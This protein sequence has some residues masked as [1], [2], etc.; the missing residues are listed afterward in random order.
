[1]AA[2]GDGSS[3]PLE[4][5][6]PLGIGSVILRLGGIG[7]VLLCSAGAFA[8]TGGWLSPDRVTP[9]KL[10]AGF[11]A[12][13][14]P[15]PGFRRNH[16]KGVCATGMFETA[17]GEAAKLSKATVFAAPRTPV[18]A[19]I[20]FAGG[21]PAVPD[22]TALVRSLALQLLP[23]GGGEWRTGMINIPVFPFRTARD[24]YDQAQAG[25]PDPATG[26][27]DPAKMQAFV[28]A[29]PDFARAG[30]L[31]GKR[32]V[33]S[34]FADTTYNGLHTFHFIG[35]DGAMTP[36]RWSAVPVDPVAPAAS[37][38]ATAAG[39]S[40]ALFDAFIT[41]MAQG[42]V[43]WRLV[44]TVGGATETTDPSRPWPDGLRTVEAGTVTLA[45]VEAE[46]GGPCTRV[47][48]DPLV[49]PDGIKRSDDDEIISTRSAAYARSFRLR[50]GEASAKPPSAVTSADVQKGGRS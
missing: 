6:P 31:I 33:T 2:N 3:R 11:E 25:L 48:Y 35:A 24:F 7:A 10:V 34:G 17:G 39:D 1:M 18:V 32:A 49:L 9:K 22:S 30:G 21:L 38:Q 45:R 44:V 20:A 15:H 27:P 26:K 8:Y 42:P 47:N 13:N 46:D 14:G 37:A 12:A 28:A 50:E 29:H 40:N 36:V 4:Q 41:R 23:P 5:Q 19:R 16:A 43:R